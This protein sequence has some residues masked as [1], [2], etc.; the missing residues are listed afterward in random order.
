V[1]DDCLIAAGSLLSKGKTFPPGTLIL[2]NPAR[3]VRPLTAEEI[4]G[5]AALA[6]KYVKVKDA[7]LDPRA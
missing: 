6:D 1:G 3:A 7:Y 4:R 5:L 2:G